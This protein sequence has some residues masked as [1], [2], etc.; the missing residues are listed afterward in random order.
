MVLCESQILRRLKKWAL[1]R[2]NRSERTQLCRVL[3]CR[4]KGNLL[5]LVMVICQSARSDMVKKVDN[6]V[7]VGVLFLSLLNFA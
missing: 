5:A 6:S 2:Q 1:N 3:S 4:A 7:N